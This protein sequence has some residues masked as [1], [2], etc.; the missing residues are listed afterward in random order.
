MTS[1][2]PQTTLN[3]NK[4]VFITLEE[5]EGLVTQL[6]DLGAKCQKNKSFLIASR[7]NKSEAVY[8]WHLNEPSN[9]SEKGRNEIRNHS[10]AIRDEKL[11]RSYRSESLS[12]RSAPR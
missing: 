7:G 1:P 4:I 10:D 8:S 11:D 5:L 6:I 2:A 3:P 9:S 12:E